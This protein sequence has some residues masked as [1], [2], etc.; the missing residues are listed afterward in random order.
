MGLR[1]EA[2]L[3]T[4]RGRGLVL[5]AD[6]SAFDPTTL[7]LEGF[8][9]APFAGAPWVGQSSAG[10]SGSRNL[11]DGG[12]GLPP[13]AGA[14]LNGFATADFDGVDDRLYSSV[15]AETFLPPAAYTALVLYRA[16]VAPAAAANV[17]DDP[18]LLGDGFGLSIAHSAG[19][20]G[21]AHYDNGAAAWRQARVSATA[22]GAWVLGKVKYDGANIYLGTNGGAWSAPTSAGARGGVGNSMRLGFTT[23]SVPAFFDGRMAAIALAT[24]LTDADIDNFRSYLNSRFALSI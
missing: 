12:S 7:S 9:L 13:S 21:V 17:Y 14:A 10:G 18:S 1:V 19:G 23:I 2:S 8:W 3:V 11:T 16:D 24:S 20:F 15:N 6:A 4:R 22:T 5:P